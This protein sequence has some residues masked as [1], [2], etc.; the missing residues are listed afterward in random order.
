MPSWRPRRPVRNWAR[1]AIA[2][3]LGFDKARCWPCAGP[4][5]ILNV[6]CSG[7]GSRSPAPD[8]SPRFEGRAANSRPSARS[9]PSVNAE[10][11]ETESRPGHRVVGLP[12]SSSAC[13]RRIKPGGRHTGEARRVNSGRTPIRSSTSATGRAVNPSPTTTAGRRSLKAAGVRDGRLHDARH[14]ATLLLV[15]GVSERT[16]MSIMGWSSTSMAARYQHVTDRSDRPSPKVGGLL[17]ATLTPL[18]KAN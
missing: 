15:L 8:L 1:W 9:G 7:Y 11:G 5:L 18:A 16:V 6:G 13:S 12:D 2:L 17:W 4:T 10:L 14:T 3:A